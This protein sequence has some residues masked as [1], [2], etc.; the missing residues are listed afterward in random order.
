M[1]VKGKVKNVVDFGAFVDIGIKE[2][3]LIHVS[4]MGDRFVKNPMEVLRVGDLKEFTIISIDPVR[5]RIG[6]SLKTQAKAQT[7]Q[8]T[9]SGGGSKGRHVGSSAAGFGRAE[10]APKGGASV[11]PQKAAN[12]HDSAGRPS[13]GRQASKGRPLRDGSEDGMTYNPFADLLKRRK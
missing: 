9:G 4:E 10:S 11:N 13:T 2:S 1:K 3:A 6:L 7:G 12:G 8:A 5:R